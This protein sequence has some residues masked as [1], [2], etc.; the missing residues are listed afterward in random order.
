MKVNLDH[1][2]DSKASWVFLA[3]TCCVMSLTGGTLESFS[4]LVVVF[5]EHFGSTNAKIGKIFYA[6][7][8]L[9]LPVAAFFVFLVIAVIALVHFEG[10]RKFMFKLVENFFAQ[11]NAAMFYRFFFDNFS[12]IFVHLFSFFNGCKDACKAIT[13]LKNSFSEYFIQ[14]AIF[15]CTQ[16]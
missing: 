13:S 16:T 14:V 11:Q 15:Y 10:K 9:I 8:N 7:L 5:K 1:V 4:V 12:K 2:R 3:V 6:F